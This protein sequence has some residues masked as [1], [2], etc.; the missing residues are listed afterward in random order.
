MVGVCLCGLYV[1]QG[2]GS[3]QMHWS[4]LS[5]DYPVIMEFTITKLHGSF[6]GFTEIPDGE[7]PSLSDG[8]ASLTLDN[9]EDYDEDDG[10]VTV[11]LISFGLLSS[12]AGTSCEQYLHLPLCLQYVWC[13]LNRYNFCGALL[14]LSCDTMQDA[15]MEGDFEV[16]I[17]ASDV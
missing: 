2:D 17:S 16:V 8:Q 14:E 5:V 10:C 4:V 1:V 11:A 3:L 13:C 9:Y 15:F 6:L 7:T 12:Q